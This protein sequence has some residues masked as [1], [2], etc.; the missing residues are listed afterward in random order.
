MQPNALQNVLQ[1]F[2]PD[3]GGPLGGGGGQPMPFQL[4]GMMGGPRTEEKFMPQGQPNPRGGGLGGQPGPGLP[5]PDPIEGGGGFYGID[6]V[7][8]SD[9]ML[10]DTSV[11]SKILAGSEGAFKQRAQD[12]VSQAMA[13]AGFMGNRYGSY[14][15]REAGRQGGR[16]AL[17]SQALT[18]PLLMQ[19]LA[20]NLQNRN[21]AFQNLMQVAGG[22]QGRQDQFNLAAYQDWMQR[23]MGMFQ[24]MNP[25]QQQMQREAGRG[26]M[27]DI[28]GGFEE[29]FPGM[30]PGGGG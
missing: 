7:G 10:G 29:L 20:L 17:E 28:W 16:A 19:N 5:A 2:S 3:M 22:E 24:M 26:G 23:M 9:R 15:A 11:F 8:G 1:A 13:S 27:F 12:Y 4:P 18:Q 21:S 30:T 14:G 25:G 6:P